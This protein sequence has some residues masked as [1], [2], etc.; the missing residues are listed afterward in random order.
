LS[1]PCFRFSLCHVEKPNMR[2]VIFVTKTI[3]GVLDFF[4]WGACG[5]CW[6]SW[7]VR[8]SMGSYVGGGGFDPGSAQLYFF[9]LCGVPSI[10]ERFW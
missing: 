8:N 5:G 9:F 2:G 7:C 4:V 10:A 1:L 3:L 6:T